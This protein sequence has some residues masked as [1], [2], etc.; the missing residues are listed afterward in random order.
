MMICVN[1]IALCVFGC[2]K[3]AYIQHSQT[4]QARVALGD[5]TLSEFDAAMTI[6]EV[7]QEQAEGRADKNT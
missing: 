5:S 4:T 6:Y 7:S 3:K 1:Y 2:L